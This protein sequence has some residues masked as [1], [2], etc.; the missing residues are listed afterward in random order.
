MPEYDGGEA[1]LPETLFTNL[2]QTEPINCLVRVY[3]IS[4]S[5]SDWLQRIIEHRVYVLCCLCFRQLTCSLRTLVDWYVMM[6]IMIMMM[7][8]RLMIHQ[9]N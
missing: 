8:L 4:V 9:G 5:E 7:K 1:E 6:M 2:P 3:I